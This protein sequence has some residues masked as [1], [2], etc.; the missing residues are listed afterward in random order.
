MNMLA[1]NPGRGQQRPDLFP[2]NG[3]YSYFEGSHTIYYEVNNDSGIS[4][5]DVLHQ[6][7]DPHL[8]L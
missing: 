1:E 7:M 8:H 2:E 6:S 3:C 5:I 4:I